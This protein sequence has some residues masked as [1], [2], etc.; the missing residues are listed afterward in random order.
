[1]MIMVILASALAAWLAQAPPPFTATEMMRLRRIADPQLSPDGRWVAYQATE[2]DPTSL[3]RNIDIWVVPATG[4]DPR[5]LAAHAASDTRPRWSRDGKHLAFLSTRDGSSQVWLMDAHGAAL[6]KVTS[7][8]TEVGGM[9]WIDTGT[10]LVTSDVYPACDRPDGAYGDACQRER[11]DAAG[12]PPPER[13]YDRLLYR[14]W[15]TWDDNRRAHLLVVGLDGHVRRDLTP[16]DADVPPFTVGG[17]DDYDV[18]PDGTEVAYSRKDDPRTEAISTNAELYRVP[19]SGGAPAKVAGSAGYD[20]TPRY[21]PDGSRIAFRAQD[22]AGYESDRWR[23]R[24]FDRR[25]GRISEPA[26]DFDRHVGDVAWSPDSRTVYFTAEHEARVPVFAVAA[27]GGA[28]RTVTEGGSFS[29]LRAFP[30]GRTLLASMA[31]LTRPAEVFRVATDNGHTTAVTRAND[32]VLAPFQLRAGE[33]I[34]YD[35]AAGK[36]VQAWIVKP[37]AFDPARKY[38]LLVLIHGGP[39]GEWGDAWSYRWN[40]QV[41]AAAGYVVVMPN[42]RGSVGWGQEFIDDINGDWGG[43]AYEDV[44]RG[45]DYAEALPYVDKG[46]TAAAGASYGGYLVNWIAGHTDRFKALVSH[47]GLFDLRAMYGATEEV[48]FVEWEFGGPPWVRPEMYERWSPNGH[49]EKFKTPTLVLHGEKDYRVPLEQGLGMF[50]AL[51]RQ[52]VPSRLVLFPD[53]NHWV[54]KP[55]N[56]LAWYRE[57]LGWLDR[58]TK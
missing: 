7:L 45:V 58:W 16:G 48:W 24:V 13:L 20:A 42:P 17:A 34:T 18:S 54:L 57:V 41:F 27:D 14:H 23:L 56:S 43:R 35:G 50:T 8:P 49:V 31:A 10:L 55:T 30:D 39:Q 51:Q 1:M 2:V 40:P 37:A 4:G 9:S 15:D 26:P 52:G 33:S 3:G 11:L 38:P 19:V 36:K 6:R 53:E 44:L 28:V 47:A 5:R 22:R 32:A 21:S 46:K 29:D 25:T 12:K